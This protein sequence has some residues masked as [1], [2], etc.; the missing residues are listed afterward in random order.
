MARNLFAGAL[1]GFTIGLVARELDFPTVISY[2]GDRS[3]LVMAAALA[4]AVLGLTSLRTLLSLSAA[5]C[6][7]LWLAVALTPLTAGMAEGLVRRDPIR[8]ADAVFV[9]ASGLQSDGE[10]S[11]IAMSRLLKG[12]ELLGQGLAP[13]LVL[14]ELPR[15]PRYRNAACEIM[16]AMG[17]E[18]EV[19]TV[20][21]VRTTREEAV[22]VG[23]LVRELG[24]ERVLV[25]TSPS[26][27]RRAA[28]AL[29]AEGV[30]VV[31]V[32]SIETQFD[33]ENLDE[34]QGDDRLRSFR[35]FLHE[36]AGLLYYRARGWLDR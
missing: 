11:T 16:D 13:R 34:S 31:S 33:L 7:I 17:L 15:G 19:V 22:A 36:H 20:G 14:S 35:S 4:G 30:S 5:A 6:G 1:L 10:L 8:S 12:L 26:H 23:N 32:P 3:L 29:E 2:H 25:V 18:Q 24:L 9:L 21:P 28:A 27:T